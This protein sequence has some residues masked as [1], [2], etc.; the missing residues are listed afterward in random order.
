MA[1]RYNL[2]N[3]PL[4]GCGKIPKGWEV[5]KFGDIARIRRGASPRPIEDLKYFGGG[6]GWIRI[7]DVSKS[8]KYLRQTHDHLSK[9][10]EAKSIAVNEGDVIMS[11]AATVGRPIIVK[12]QA[13][14]HD[15]F[16]TFSNLSED[17][18]NEYLY[19]LLKLEKKFVGMGQHGTQNNINSAL[20]ANTKFCKPPFQEQ[21]KIAA[22]LS[23]I[24]VL[25]ESTRE[26]IEKTKK[27]KRG[28]MQK[29]LTK[30][31]GHTKFKKVH[32]RFD[33]EIEIPEEWEVTNLSDICNVQ[34][35]SQ[36]NSNLYVGLEH[37]SQNDNRLIALG[38]KN[39]FNSNKNIFRKDNVLYGKLRPRLSKVWLA[40]EDGYCSTDIL[41]LQANE[42]IIPLILLLT[43]TDYR[44]FWYAV[45]TSAG[46][47]MPRTAWSD[48]KKF[49]VFLPSLKEQKKIA[50]ILSVVDAYIRTNQQYEMHLEKLKKGLMQKLLTGQIRV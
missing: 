49:R 45:S 38:N 18:D 8:N 5:L 47:K 3:G 43:L 41:P 4:G 46:T 11:I 22:I 24:D 19:Y 29:L 1:K 31:I 15:G 42:K 23:N 13:C 35:P 32:W 2:I 21:Q 20:V 44:F 9:L 7:S 10:G 50:S 40:N 25:I 48:M 17:V 6:R 34:E 26:T 36:I 28:L 37:I 30:G 12:M 14:I 27:L 16:V 33:R 39:K